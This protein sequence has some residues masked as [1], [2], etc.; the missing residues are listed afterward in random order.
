MATQKTLEERQQEAIARQSKLASGNVLRPSSQQIS[1]ITQQDQEV[2]QRINDSLVRTTVGRTRSWEE[3][4][5]TTS[6]YRKTQIAVESISEKE[7]EQTELR[8]QQP[9]PI[10]PE[11]QVLQLQQTRQVLDKDNVDNTRALEKIQ[12]RCNHRYSSQNRRCVF[13]NKLKDSHV[14]DPPA[15]TL[16]NVRRK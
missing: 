8:S 9:D 2:E 3:D 14:F 16:Q 5:A 13:C 1:L 6:N 4:E 7:T 10:T 12:S 11:D 15:V